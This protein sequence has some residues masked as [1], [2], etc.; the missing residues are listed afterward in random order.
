MFSS[1]IFSTKALADEQ[2]TPKDYINYL[3][4]YSIEDALDSGVTDELLAA[5]AVEGAKNT[6]EQFKKLSKKEQQDFI[7]LLTNPNTVEAIYSGNLDELDSENKKKIKWIK[8]TTTELIPAENESVNY[9][10]M[11]LATTSSTSRIIKGT[12]TMWVLGIRVTEYVIEGKYYYNSYGVTSEGYTKAYVGHNYNPTVVTDKTWE[13]G[14][15]SGGKY[16]GDAIFYY[17]MGIGPL[18]IIQLGNVFIGIVGN[19]YG[20]EDGYFYTK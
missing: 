10:N 6:L 3:K 17:K 15:V 4:N 2:Y 14:E 19:K 11:A 12:G 20:K 5:E 7:S 9:Q 1:S 8:T 13:N 16:Y 18:G